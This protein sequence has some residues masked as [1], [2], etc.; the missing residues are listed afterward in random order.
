MLYLQSSEDLAMG[1]R[2]VA[3]ELEEGSTFG[4]LLEGLEDNFGSELAEEIY[5]S[6]AQSLQEGVLALIN[7]TFAH[8]FDGTDTILHHGDT[9][10]FVPLIYGG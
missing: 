2:D 7:G 6:Q 4:E 3:V 1:K 10:I 9:I 8:N 5:D